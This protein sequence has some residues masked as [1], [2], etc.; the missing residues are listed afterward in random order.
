MLHRSDYSTAIACGIRHH[1]FE[2]AAVINLSG[3][4]AVM[5]NSQA[6]ELGAR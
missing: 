5:E 4:E 6:C 2:G 3:L 1:L